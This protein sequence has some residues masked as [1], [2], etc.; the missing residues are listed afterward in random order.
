M[1]L[2]VTARFLYFHR[3]PAIRGLVDP[4]ASYDD[5]HAVYEVVT[6]E[7]A[8][9]WRVAVRWSEL[10]K[11]LD[12]L[13]RSHRETML[14]AELPTFWKHTVRSRTSRALCAERA[15]SME[16]LLRALVSVFRASLLRKVG[17]WALR[18]FL[19]GY[20]A[21]VPT[22]PGC[23]FTVDGWPEAVLTT[24]ADAGERCTPLRRL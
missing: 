8:F 9:S 5:A 16:S 22:P 17:P 23:W 7:N 15:A 2:A 6:T 18:G 24:S 12:E 4:N 1:P 13:R 20:E 3:P 21:D 19:C 10:A 14:A 11:L